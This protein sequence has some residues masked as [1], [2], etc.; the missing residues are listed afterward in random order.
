MQR[1]G[2]RQRQLTTALTSTVFPWIQSPQST[3]TRFGRCMASTRSLSRSCWGKRQ[4]WS[5]W[6]LA[7]SMCLLT[8]SY[9]IFLHRKSSTFLVVGT[10]ISGY[11][12]TSFTVMKS[13]TLTI[14]SISP[15][16]IRVLCLL[17]HAGVV[18]V[19]DEYFNIFLELFSRSYT[20]TVL[21]YILKLNTVIIRKT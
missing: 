10:W 16:K 2:E 3:K 4:I 18:A 9:I 20:T 17:V 13:L 21:H 14:P 11:H 15:T 5:L 1:T 8:A 7:V 19:A 6:L 12:W